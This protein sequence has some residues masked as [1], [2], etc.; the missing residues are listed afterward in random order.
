MNHQEKGQVLADLGKRSFHKFIYNKFRKHVGLPEI[1]CTINDKMSQCVIPD[2]DLLE[3]L[4]IDFRWLFPQQTD[5]MILDEHSYRTPFGVLFKENDGGS[6]FALADAPMADMNDL[7]DIDEYN[8][9]PDT[10]ITGP[11]EGLVEKAKYLE[12]NTDYVIGLDGIRGGILQTAIEL[13]GFNSF[14]IDL[15][16]RK[17]YANKLLNKVLEVYKGYYTTYLNLV[18]KYG[19]VVF[20]QDDFGTQSSMLMS[21]EMWKEMVMPKE[22]ELIRHLKKLAPYIKVIFH[23]DGCI[24]PIISDMA[25]TGVDILNPVQTSLDD[26]SDTHKLNAEYGGKICFHGGIDVQKVLPGAGPEEVRVEVNRRICDLGKGGGYIVTTCHNIG[27]D[28]PVQ[29]L[30]AMYDAI[31]EFKRYPLKRLA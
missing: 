14:F 16:L 30:K 1:E 21:P 23:S 13:R 20:I 25:E 2:E 5:I 31:K 8:F 29:N 17:E 10:A 22:A 27:A 28:I 4:D 12:K 24:L 9:W 3:F 11:Y 26:F 6:Y 7:E 19:H 18:G 15:S